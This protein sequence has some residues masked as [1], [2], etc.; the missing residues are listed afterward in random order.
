MCKVLKQRRFWESLQFD[1]LLLIVLF[2]IAVFFRVILDKTV[3]VLGRSHLVFLTIVYSFL[4]ILAYSFFKRKIWGVLGIEISFKRLFLYN[5]LVLF[6]LLALSAG[7]FL[8]LTYA[9]KQEYSTLFITIYFVLLTVA[10]YFFFNA[11]QL[12]R[13]KKVDQKKV[14]KVAGL[15]MLLIL[16]IG[17]IYFL[18]GRFVPGIVIKIVQLLFFFFIL[19]MN[20]Y[21]RVVISKK[22][23]EKAPLP[24]ETLK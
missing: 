21:N 22:Q 8:F 9:V 5:L 16:A 7:I 1:V 23:S 6:T 10:F 2:G 19:L 12:S 18:G 4:L 17:I 13:F 15:E 14:L 24:S 20:G 3:S 11:F